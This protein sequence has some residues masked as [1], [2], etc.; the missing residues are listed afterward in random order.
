MLGSL[1]IVFPTPHEGGALLVRHR[2]QEW[3]FDPGWEF[4]ASRTPTIGYVVLLND[5][6]HEVTPITFGH[7]VTLTYNLY[8]AVDDPAF[9]GP[10][11]G[12]FP[13]PPVYERRFRESFEALLENPEFLPHGGT[14]G[15]GLRHSYPIRNEIRHV[16]GLLK[17]SDAVVYRGFRVL[18]FQPALYMYVEWT[19][20]VVSLTEGGLLDHVKE[21]QGFGEDNVDVTKEV[22]EDGGH[23]V[24]YD[25]QYRWGKYGYEGAEKMEWVTPMTTFS[26]QK[27]TY[28]T[29]GN[30]PIEKIAYWDLCLVVR[31]GKAGGRLMYPTIAQLRKE[32]E[33]N[34]ANRYSRF[35]SR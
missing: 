8:R 15:F 23:I 31:I 25:D 2:G 5:V 16:Y 28:N 19:S 29:F 32:Y 12:P 4:T 14:L 35:W 20:E 10:A 3:S 11:T 33:R 21:F 27:S 34:Y 22:L 9:E 30:E 1:V 24:Y 6:E 18:G 26:R 13:S 17:A 7:R